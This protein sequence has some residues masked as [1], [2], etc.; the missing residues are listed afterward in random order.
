M[1]HQTGSLFTADDLVKSMPL[2]GSGWYH[3]SV[4]KTC[5]DFGLLQPGDITHVIK[6]SSR[7]PADTLAKAFHEVLA[8]L[9]DK[10]VKI[11]FDCST[12]LARDASHR[13][14]GMWGRRKRFVLEASCSQRPQDEQIWANWVSRTDR[15]SR[16]RRV[17]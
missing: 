8:V 13:L 9:P 14:V 5:I 4:V 17:I 2:R 10:E 3:Q 16:T 12:N 11:S 6:A 1:R 15:A 7:I